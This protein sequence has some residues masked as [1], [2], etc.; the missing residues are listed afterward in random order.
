MS[1]R[2]D[3]TK[4]VA[5]L[6]RVPDEDGWHVVAEDLGGARVSVE[7]RGGSVVAVQAARDGDP[8]D[9][10]F[11][12]ASQAGQGATRTAKCFVCVCSEEAC[13]CGTVPCAHHSM[14]DT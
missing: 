13:T 5:D 2:F 3:L 7:M 9:A 11:L 4:T 6:G 14:P 10:F 12:I 1:Y 8:V